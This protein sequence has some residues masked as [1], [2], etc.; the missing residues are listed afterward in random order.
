M[1][2][3][4]NSTEVIRTSWPSLSNER[5][6]SPAGKESPATKRM[7]DEPRKPAKPRPYRNVRYS[8]PYKLLYPFV[9]TILCV[10]TQCAQEVSASRTDGPAA[11]ECTF[12]EE[13]FSY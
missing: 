8:V 12:D 5:N 7:E 1:L 10:V 2:L 9:V 4:N 11:K 6:A 3:A 13:E